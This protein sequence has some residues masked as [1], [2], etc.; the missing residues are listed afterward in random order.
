M[1]EEEEIKHKYLS[2][3][4][5]IYLP[6]Y[7]SISTRLYY[8]KIDASVFIYLSIIYY[9]CIDACVFTIRQLFWFVSYDIVHKYICTIRSFI[10]KR[11]CMRVLTFCHAR[12]S[13]WR[14]RGRRRWKRRRGGGEGGGKEGRRRK[15][16]SKHSYEW[17]GHWARP[18]DASRGKGWRGGRYQHHICGWFDGIRA[19][20]STGCS[21]IFSTE[22]RGWRGLCICVCLCP[23]LCGEGQREFR[24]W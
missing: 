24:G 22:V 6:N 11:A 7:L 20:I 23:Y 1:E 9:I 3:Y 17:G 19:Q 10:C 21:L 16:Y 14:Y 4:R 2:I 5:S 18:R 15:V 13:W 8:R 12:T